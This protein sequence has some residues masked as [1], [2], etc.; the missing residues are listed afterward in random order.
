M[1]KIVG[2]GSDTAS[3]MTGKRGGVITL[4]RRDYPWLIGVHCL[5]HSW[6]STQDMDV[7]DQPHI[8]MGI[9]E[10]DNDSDSDHES[11]FDFE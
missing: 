2:F 5:A 10:E 9:P 11:D 4:M 1:G 8:D 6:S 3:D 7:E